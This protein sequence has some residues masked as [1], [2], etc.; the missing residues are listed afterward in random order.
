AF[1]HIINEGSLKINEHGAIQP[2]GDMQMAP[3]KWRDDNQKAEL[4]RRGDKA[5]DDLL[6][7][8]LDKIVDYPEWESSR[9]YIIRTSLVISKASD[10]N[11]FVP[12]GSS[13]RVFLR[14]LPDLKKA[15]RI[16][17]SYVCNDLYT[18]IK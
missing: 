14:L 7:I 11:E 5:L 10:F 15:D 17:K 6:D 9:H 18:R 13:T 3:S 8:L 16:L 4:I 1:Y 2:T 12:I